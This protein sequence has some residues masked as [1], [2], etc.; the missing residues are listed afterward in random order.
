VYRENISA[1]YILQGC[2]WNPIC[3]AAEYI[4]RFKE[5]EALFLCSH[6]WNL[7]STS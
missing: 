4:S 1:N 2:H 7:P 6:N 3:S 5:P